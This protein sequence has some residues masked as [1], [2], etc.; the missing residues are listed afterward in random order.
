[1]K[2]GG[3][4]GGVRKARDKQKRVLGKEEAKVEVREKAGKERRKTRG[5]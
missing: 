1:M 5:R 3:E 4:G 2:G